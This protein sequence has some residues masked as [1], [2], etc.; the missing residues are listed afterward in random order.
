MARA[1]PG[2]VPHQ[3]EAHHVDR[4]RAHR[5]CHAAHARQAGCDRDSRRVSRNKLAGRRGLDS[6][7]PDPER[8]RSCRTS[9]RTHCRHSTR[10][11]GC[12][13]S[14]LGWLGNTARGCPTMS[15]GVCRSPRHIRVDRRTRRSCNRW[16]CST[17]S[18][19]SRS[20]LCSS[21]R[22]YST[23]RRSSTCPRSSRRWPTGSRR[24]CSICRSRSPSRSGIRTRRRGSCLTRSTCRRSRH[25]PPCSRTTRSISRLCDNTARPGTPRR[26][27]ISARRYAATWRKAAEVVLRAAVRPA[28][29]V[30]RRAVSIAPGL[31]VEATMPAGL[32]AVAR[33]TAFLVARAT[34]PAGACDS[35]GLAPLPARSL[36]C[37][38][39][40]GRE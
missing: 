20:R 37:P 35:A 25:A 18:R 8:S 10:V 40:C 30:T 5:P 23:I 4:H 16:R 36:L 17:W 13:R 21:C 19:H 2:S 6:I 39:R 28:A 26:P 11:Q 15:R 31:L 24:R 22:R 34:P 9:Q 14:R 38:R 1:Y 32:G 7:H 33:T 27:R 29:P 3:R 12:N